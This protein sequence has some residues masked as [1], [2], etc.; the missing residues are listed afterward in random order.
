MTFQR[1]VITNLVLFVLVSVPT[2]LTVRYIFMAF[3][4]TDATSTN[5][6]FCLA[7]LI[8]GECSMLLFSLM[9]RTLIAQFA[10]WPVTFAAL[11]YALLS[12]AAQVLD[13]FS[14]RV[15]I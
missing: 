15:H 2:A 1:T 5:A 14:I 13:L 12:A 10:I 7:L 3:G 8:P 11:C 4:Q 9:F 6:A